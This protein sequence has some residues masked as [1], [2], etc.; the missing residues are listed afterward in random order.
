[1]VATR[2]SGHQ[3][4]RARP[5]T[6]ES[7]ID[8]D[9]HDDQPRPARAAG[10]PVDAPPPGHPGHRRG[11]GRAAARRR[12][13]S[14]HIRARL[15]DADG[16]DRSLDI[17]R[18]GLP[19]VGSRQLAW[20]DLDLA[21]ADDLPP[22]VIERLGLRD[23]DHE[24]IVREVGRAGL[25]AASGRLHLTLIAVELVGD[26]EADVGLAAREVDLVA[27][28]GLV[29]SIRRGPIQALERFEARLGDD[30]VLGVLTAGDL[31]S[32]LVDELV[33]GYLDVTEAIE[34]RIDRL[35]D[36]ALRARSSLDVLGEI[37]RLRRR[38]SEVRRT[39]APHRA[40]LSALAR[41][42]LGVDE[43][44]GAPWP[45]LVDR[46]EHATAS[47]E[48]LRDALIG[49]YDIHMGREAQRAHDV[50]KLPT[51]LSAV[52]LPA[53]VLAGIMGMNF[54]VPFFDEPGNFF[55]VLAAM[56][57]FSVALLGVARWRG[58]W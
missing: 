54:Q 1:M 14:G 7:S 35:D 36:A 56:A 25:H 24:R 11:R 27:A 9:P 21:V 18:D 38:I 23:D 15:F 8:A 40:A 13:L 19:D 58:W 43:G 55:L 17:E 22:A 6:Q 44:I 3:I 31:L 41:P 2:A 30:T 50:M 32:A 5:S 28:P 53:V 46:I 34:R 48:S 45:G 29:V 37:V 47:V 26:D 51:L 42:E 10:R 12:P 49:T 52:L 20:I 4:P 16:R 39:L 33:T 57:V